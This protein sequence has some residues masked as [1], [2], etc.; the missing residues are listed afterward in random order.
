MLSQIALFKLKKTRIIFFSIGGDGSIGDDPPI[1]T[2]PSM[3][4]IYLL[5]FITS[6]CGHLPR[7]H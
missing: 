5:T 6:F 7:Y 2:I 3:Y 4:K 1:V